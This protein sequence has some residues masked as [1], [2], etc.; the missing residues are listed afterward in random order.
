[1]PFRPSQ[2]PGSPMRFRRT[3]RP[4]PKSQSPRICPSKPRSPSRRIFR[5][6][7]SPRAM[8]LRLIRRNRAYRAAAPSRRRPWRKARRH[9]R[10]PRQPRRKRPPSR[11]YSLGRLRPR[12]RSSRLPMPEANAQDGSPSGGKRRKGMW[13]GAGPRRSAARLPDSAARLAARFR[14][15]RASCS[16]AAGFRTRAAAFPDRVR[17]LPGAAL[18]A[19]CAGAAR[20][21]ASWRRPKHRESRRPDACRYG[22]SA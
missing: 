5:R 12:R 3:C 18:N 1:M 16:A 21:R 10:L 4:K 6:P 22:R 11:R 17:R 9:L 7:I 14:M 8:P 19:C 2:P 13:R 15:G 20:P